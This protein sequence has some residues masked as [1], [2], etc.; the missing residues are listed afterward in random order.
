[1]REQLLATP[2]PLISHRG[3]LGV[4]FLFAISGFVIT[5]LL[6]QEGSGSGRIS[7]RKFYVRRAPRIFP[8]LHSVGLRIS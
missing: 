3:F 4:D 5:T 8:L 7:L 6:V 1:L 2:G